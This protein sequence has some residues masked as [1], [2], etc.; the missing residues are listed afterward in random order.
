M[1]EGGSKNASIFYPN[2][3]SEPA[4]STYTVFFITYDMEKYSNNAG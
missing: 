2:L 3:I 4:M 1:D